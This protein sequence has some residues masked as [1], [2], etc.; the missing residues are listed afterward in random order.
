VLYGLGYHWFD[1]LCLGGILHA[2]EKRRVE[3][4]LEKSEEERLVGLR[5]PIKK[6]TLFGLG[7]VLAMVVIA[8]VLY[9]SYSV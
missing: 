2:S 9:L 5:G 4:E 8:W 7:V 1:R 3:M 6:I